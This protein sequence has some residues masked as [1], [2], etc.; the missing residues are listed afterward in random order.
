LATLERFISAAT[1]DAENINIR[2]YTISKFGLKVWNIKKKEYVVNLM[3]ILSIFEKKMQDSI[4]NDCIT[5]NATVIVA[6][7]GAE[8]TT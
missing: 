2:K 8:N 1:Y 4:V 3:S 6:Q 5:H 7:C